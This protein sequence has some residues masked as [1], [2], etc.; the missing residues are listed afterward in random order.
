LEK[1]EIDLQVLKRAV[2]DVLDHM[3]ED[4]NLTTVSIDPSK[5][6][7]WDLDEPALYDM[8]KDPDDFTVGRLTDDYHFVGGVH[9]G[10]A[11]DH[12]FNLIH[13]APL[14]R[15]LAKAVQS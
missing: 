9:R 10:Q 5:D 12:A 11:G 3:M 6:C 15:Y 2:T 13:I 14:L 4:L 1:S 7:Y 8:S